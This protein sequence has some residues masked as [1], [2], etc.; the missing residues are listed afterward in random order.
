MGALDDPR[1]EEQQVAAAKPRS[2]NRR[3]TE[4][5]P[6]RFT[7][8]DKLELAREAE[9]RGVTIPELLREAWFNSLGAAS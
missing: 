5:I 4:S 6:V 7:K 9:R 3:L 2:E 8:A 1:S